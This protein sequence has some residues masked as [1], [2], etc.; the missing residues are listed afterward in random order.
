MDCTWERTLVYFCTC[1]LIHMLKNCFFITV[2]LFLLLT[3]L[4]F[5]NLHFLFLLI[6]D[7][8]DKIFIS[9]DTATITTSYCFA[10]F[11]DTI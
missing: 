1:I 4:V 3:Y 7:Y 2:V 5:F 6:Q 11:C 10:V 8:L 9:E